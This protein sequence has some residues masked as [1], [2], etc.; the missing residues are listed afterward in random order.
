MKMTFYCQAP[1]LLARGGSHLNR[2]GIDAILQGSLYRLDIGLDTSEAILKGRSSAIP[3]ESSRDFFCH[4]QSEAC[5]RRDTT[6]ME[7][8]RTGD[9]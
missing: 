5:K 9:S 4:Y 7:N 6:E 3:A 8:Y 2:D 1:T